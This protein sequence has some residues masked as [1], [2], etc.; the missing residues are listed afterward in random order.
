MLRSD[1]KKNDL[2]NALLAAAQNGHEH[3][4]HLLIEAGRLHTSFPVFSSLLS[5]LR[6]ANAHLYIAEFNRCLMQ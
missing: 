2:A 4:L 3:I 6:E 1:L 5:I